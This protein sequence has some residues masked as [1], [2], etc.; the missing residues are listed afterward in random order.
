VENPNLYED[1]LTEERQVPPVEREEVAHTLK[2]DPD[3]VGP[4]EPVKPREEE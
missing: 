4:E 1:D 3:I 2:L